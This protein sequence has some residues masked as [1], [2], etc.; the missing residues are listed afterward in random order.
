MVAILVLLHAAACAQPFRLPTNNRALFQPGR[1]A[2]FFVGTTG[3]PWTSGC[4]GCVRSDGWQMHEGLDIKALTRDSRGEPADPVMA[5]ADGTVAYLNLKPALS[6]YGK[7]VLI[8]H[9]IEGLEIYSN[10]AH[11]SQ[12]R[13]GLRAGQTVKAGEVIGLMGRTA[14]TRE[15]I[16]KDRAHVHF[17]LDLLVSDR[18]PEWFRKTNPRERNDHGKWNGINLVGLDPRLILL[19]QQR[20]GAGFSLLNLVRSQTELCRVLVRD[21]SFP[22]LR[23]Y[24]MLIKRNPLAEREGVAGFEIALNYN[25]LPFQ[26]VPR[27]ASEIRGKARVQLLSV[28]EAEYRKNPCRK[29]VVKRNGRWELTNHGTALLGLLTY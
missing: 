12:V 25:G 7:Y 16:S 2:E 26:L 13:A 1:E 27:A 29:L 3:R 10:Y 6:R 14:N 22:W 11:L 4:F 21:T 18:F 8:G 28:H 17:E 19:A 23:R 20:Q 15:G 9:Q 24:P 5:T